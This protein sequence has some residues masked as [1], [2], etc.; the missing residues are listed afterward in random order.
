MFDERYSPA[1]LTE[2]NFFKPL[3][4]TDS[5]TL[6]HRGALAPVTR[7][8]ADDN[9][10]LNQQTEYTETEDWKK[11]IGDQA[12]KTGDQ[13]R[14][15][16]EEY[17]HQRSQRPGTLIITEATFISP[18]AGGYENCPGI[19]TDAQKD[20]FAK[21][22]NAVH[23]NK[24]YI[25]M[26]L[27]NLGRASNPAVLKKH[28]LPYISSSDKYILTGDYLETKKQSEESG[29]LLRPITIEEIEQFKKDYVHATKNALEAGI[30]GVE[31]H[32]ANGYLFNQFLDKI[33][34]GSFD[35]LVEKFGGDKIALRLSPFGSFGDMA[36]AD[37]VEETTAFY[38][39]LLDE[40][41][42]RR[43]V[44]KGPVYISL[45]EPR[46]DETAGAQ[47]NKANTDLL[48]EFVY[49]H[50]KGV[51]VRAGGILLDAEYTKKVLD[52]H[53]RT[54]IAFGRYFIANPDLIDRLEGE[55][56]I[57]KYDRSTFYTSGF[58]GYVDYPYYKPE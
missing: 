12:N 20:S 26:Q 30:D 9:L 24:S 34:V 54:V 3:K 8:R 29:N 32:S 48:I 13:K 43:A 6:Q 31:L 36:G 41:E 15:M 21:V 53:D 27:W 25:F 16:A 57:N 58:K 23:A 17:Y 49:K 5:I 4:L 56:P 52:T 19:Y 38:S 50:F 39:Y 40:F 2:T 51:I 28:G 22:A 45:V 35:L 46:H 47:E 14:G 55:H 37:D 10:V 33:F 11:F 18:G 7:V 44:N 42:K 1:S